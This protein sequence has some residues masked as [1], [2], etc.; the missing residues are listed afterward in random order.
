MQNQHMSK[1]FGFLALIAVAISAPAHAQTGPRAEGLD[2][3]IGAANAPVTIIEYASITCPH[4]ARFHSD[5]L[6]RRGICGVLSRCPRRP[7]GGRPK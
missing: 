3:V 7:M 4:C 6:S 5:V 1:I 2:F